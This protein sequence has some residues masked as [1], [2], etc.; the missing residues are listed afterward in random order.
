MQMLVRLAERFGRK[1]AFVGRAMV[2]NAEIAMRLGYLSMPAGLQIRD[3]E[4]PSHPP[5]QV[6]CI[7]TGSQG[8]PRSALSRIAID[9]HRHVKIG[10]GDTVVLSARAIPGNEK[11]IG[12]VDQSP[13][14]PRRRRRDR[15]DQARAR[16]RATAAKRS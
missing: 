1:V 11:A 16:L 2:Q 15:G 14:A 4:V 12:R 5:S 10:P 13:D 3:S 6:L 8:E 7:T 9:D